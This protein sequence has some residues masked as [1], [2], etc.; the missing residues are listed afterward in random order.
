MAGKAKAEEGTI[1]IESIQSGS[2]SVGLIGKTPLIFNRMA[3]KV[4]QQLLVPERGRR[5]TN[6]ER[7]ASGPKHN[8]LREYRDSP[9]RMED[10]HAPTLLAIP[11][12]AVKRA[13]ADAALDI[14][15]ARKAQIGRLV[16]VPGEYLPLFG[17]TQLKMDVVRMADINHTPDVRTR[18]CA[19]QW[20]AIVEIQFVE[21]LLDR[22]GIVNLLA[23][24]GRIVG[25]GDGRQQKGALDFGLF[26]VVDL[27]DPRLKAIVDRGGREAQIAALADP[28]FYDDEARALYEWWL[29]GASADAANPTMTCGGSGN[30]SVPKKKSPTKS[31]ARNGVAL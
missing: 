11:A 28:T 1:V 25:I 2:L 30:V 10:E 20:A 5:T 23:A 4:R 12:S 6:A 8:P 24:A 3:E 29:E 19:R 26:D 17:T 21:P 18:A 13:L 15:G 31:R 14:P 9:Y 16:W 27:T 7:K 22:T